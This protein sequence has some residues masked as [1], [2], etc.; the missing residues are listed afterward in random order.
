MR[1]APRSAWL[2]R[3]CAESRPRGQAHDFGTRNFEVMR[4]WNRPE[5]YRRTMALFAEKLR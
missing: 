4:A 2:R 1:E 3:N 5:V